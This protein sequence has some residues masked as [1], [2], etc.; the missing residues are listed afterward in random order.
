LSTHPGVMPVL[1]GEGG[2]ALPEFGAQRAHPA[3]CPGDPRRPVPRR[4]AQSPAS[5]SSVRLSGRG[6]SGSLGVGG[7]RPW[8]FGSVCQPA[9]VFPY[10]RATCCLPRSTLSPSAPRQRRGLRFP[11]VARGGRHPD[12][13][14]ASCPGPW[15]NPR[16]GAARVGSH[17]IGTALNRGV[18]LPILLAELRRRARPSSVWTAARA[19]RGCDWVLATREPSG[20]ASPPMPEGSTVVSRTSALGFRRGR[21]QGVPR[22][23]GKPSTPAIVGMLRR[24]L[25]RWLGK[26]PP[27]ET[28]GRGASQPGELGH[29]TRDQRGSLVPAPAETDPLR[30]WKSD[31]LGPRRPGAVEP[32]SVVG[33]EARRRGLVGVEQWAELRRQHF[34]GRVERSWR[35]GRASRAT[36]SGR[37]ALAGAAE[38]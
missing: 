11:A 25:I 13:A 16:S 31:P 14:R 3:T 5:H 26:H 20:Y 27:V 35:G 32:G 36:R 21:Y 29:E 2:G 18:D 4:R 8:S 38:V 24:S 28:N 33:I 37:A 7:E 12:T 23:G 1:G 34:V 22:T 30:R 17:A 6:L 19:W 15:F 10:R 9:G